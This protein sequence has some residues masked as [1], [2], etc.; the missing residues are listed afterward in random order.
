LHYISNPDKIGGIINDIMR[1]LIITPIDAGGHHDEYKGLLTKAFSELGHEVIHYSQNN[2]KSNIATAIDPTISKKSKIHAAIFFKFCKYFKSIWD[3][4]GQAI[5]TW[6]GLFVQIDN[7][8]KDSK[9]PDLLFFECLDTVVG[10]YL[11]KRYINKYLN[12]PFSGILI[13]PSVKM[14]IPKKCFKRGPLDSYNILKSDRCISIGVL[15]DDTIPKLSK[16]LSKPVV[17]L[18]DVVSVQESLHDVLLGKKISNQANGRYIIGNW[19]S[20]EQRKGTSEFLQMSID[21]PA[22]E[23]FFV[24]GGQVHYGSL[25]EEHKKIIQKSISGKS[26]NLLVINKWLTDEELL[27]GMN[28][29]D[30]IFAAYPNWRYSSGIVG[31]SAALRVPILVNDG[32][33]MARRVRDFGIG[34]VKQKDEV[35][36]EWVTQNIDQIRKLRIASSFKDGCKKYCEKFGFENWKNSVGN[37]LEP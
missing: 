11:S 15:F 35:V 14:Q 5:S 3:I 9:R 21:L 8:E 2:R 4:R 29:C 24:M 26:T 25:I 22:Q 12:I 31:K 30:L 37:L 7:L 19:G 10:Q 1:I 6:Q 34:F 36:S 17:E 28:I 32:Y 23:Y 27:S 13:S 16:R 18:P 33:V 20:L